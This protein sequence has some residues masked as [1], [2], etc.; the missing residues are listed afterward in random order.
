MLTSLSD[1]RQ[2][3]ID[4]RKYF[5]SEPDRAIQEMADSLVP[6]YNTEIIRE[7]T[8]LPMS[9]SDR[10]QEVGRDETYTIVDLMRLDLY[11]YYETQVTLAWYELSNGKEEE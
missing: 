7:W 11:L 1:I 9:E 6:I 5:E 2:Q 3:V 10:W 4:E 8:D